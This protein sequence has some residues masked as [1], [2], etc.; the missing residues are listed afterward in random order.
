MMSG[1]PVCP[2]PLMPQIAHVDGRNC[3]GPRAPAE[4][5]P[6]L[7]PS[8]L[9]IWPMAART[10]QDIPGQYLAAD[11]WNSCRYV[12]GSW[13]EVT[14]VTGSCSCCWRRLTIRPDGPSTFLTLAVSVAMLR[15]GALIRPATWFPRPSGRQE[16]GFT[17]RSSPVM[18]S[19]AEAP[20]VTVR[21][22]LPAS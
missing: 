2:N 11:A 7:V 6:L 21:L 13:P 4:D 22:M 19:E 5:G 17:S 1:G 8:P 3:I 16:R 12:A 14:F 15:A 9:S 10:V 18:P 20:N